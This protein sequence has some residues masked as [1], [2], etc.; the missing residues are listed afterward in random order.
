MAGNAFEFNIGAGDFQ[1]GAGK[2]LKAIKTVQ[3]VKAKNSVTA[4]AKDLILQHPTYMSS[5][6]DPESMMIY[7]KAVEKLLAALHLAVWSADT[8]FGVDT[9]TANGTRDFIKKYHANNDD[10][11]KVSYAGNL[12]KNVVAFAQDS[13]SDTEN[14]TDD[15]A[16]T[17]MSAEESAV[18]ISRNDIEKMWITL[19][20]TLNMDMIN[21]KY[22]PYEKI[23]K[24]MDHMTTAI[25]AKTL[26]EKINNGLTSATNSGPEA[27][28]GGKK[29]GHLT[30]LQNAE[31]IKNDKITMLEPTM[32]NVNFFVRDGDNSRSQSAVIGVKT[33]I[34]IIN[35]SYLRSNVINT[36]QS[37]NVGFNFVK[38]TRGEAKI[39]KDF[40]FN[41]TQL[42]EDAI[43]RNKFDMFFS[44]MRKRRRNASAYKGGNVNINPISLMV[45]SMSDVLFIKENAG[46]D[47]TQVKTAQK[48]M[49]SLYLLGFAIIDTATGMVSTLFD[50]F[51][52]FASTTLNSLKLSAKADV[53]YSQI[54][55]SLKLMGRI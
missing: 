41:V 27:Y 29:D 34:R 21:D 30:G 7:A 9:T 10:P 28:M 32:V 23:R 16:V 43:N 1:K 46:Y 45:I 38:W 19:E 3:S 14:I 31:I 42:K 17:I 51:G 36:L 48:L 39:A 49:N 37:G 50:E 25:E 40:I 18:T 5:D 8:S 44:A 54:K 2:T 15:S 22:L 20:S 53:D 33:M 11:D 26:G 4:M 55:D 6:I 24:T 35:T 52:D 13:A 47:L 12:I